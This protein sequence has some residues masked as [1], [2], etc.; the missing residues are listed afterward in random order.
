MS[1]IAEKLLR[2]T[3]EWYPHSDERLTRIE[4][5]FWEEEPS[6]PLRFQQQ[7]AWHR[8]LARPRTRWTIT[9]DKGTVLATDDESKT[10]SRGEGLADALAAIFGLCDQP[11]EDG[12]ALPDV[13][14]LLHATEWITRLW[15]QTGKLNSPWLKPHI[16]ASPR[17][18]VVFEWWHN[19]KSLTVFVSNERAEYMLSWGADI[20]EEMSDGDADSN[21]ARRRLWLSLTGR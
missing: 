12:D 17:G 14:T 10:R 11:T 13:A 9:W 3:H 5:R 21:E 16:V 15:E 1:A 20:H 2:Q 8:R 4:P 19:E 18:E 7:V 6:T